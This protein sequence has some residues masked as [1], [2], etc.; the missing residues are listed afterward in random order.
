MKAGGEEDEMRRDVRTEKGQRAHMYST[1][2]GG[3]C[4]PFCSCRVRDGDQ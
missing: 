1:V 2:P 4:W 3:C